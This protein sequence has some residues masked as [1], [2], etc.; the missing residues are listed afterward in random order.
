[1]AGQP[2][3]AKPAAHFRSHRVNRGLYVSAFGQ[4]DCER[5][6]VRHRFHFR[7]GFDRP[8]L[9][10]AHAVEQHAPVLAEQPQHSLGLRAIQVAERLDALLTQLPLGRCADSAQGAH[11]QR[12]DEAEL[13]S[14][15][16]D[17]QPPGLV[18]V[19]RELRNR[20]RRPHANRTRHAEVGDAV[21]NALGHDDRMLSVHARGTDVEK[22]LVDAHLLH[23]RGFVEQ[24][25]HH[26]VR[27][28]AIPVEMAARP[29]G[30]G[31][32]PRRRRRRHRG[33]HAVLARLVGRSRDHA[34]FSRI[35]ADNDRL[36]PPTGMIE[37]LDRGEERIEVDE[38]NRPPDPRYR[39]ERLDRSAF[40][41][42]FARLSHGMSL[43]R[44]HRV[45]YATIR[46]IT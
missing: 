1:M 20:L 9:Q 22:R 8:V 40:V 34:A 6:F 2:L 19:G 12:V 32:K 13:A 36:A 18:H 17:R 46:T 39:S 38:Q 14:G 10:A 11:G 27:H 43:A 26:P 42:P 3:P 37:L 24:N 28:F 21:L 44:H 23:M 31:A 30:V 25:G 7:I 16:D 33:M 5:R 45:I 29:N 35:T 41:M 15:H 4:I